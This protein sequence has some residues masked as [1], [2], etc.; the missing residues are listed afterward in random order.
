MVNARILRTLDVSAPPGEDAIEYLSAASGLALIGR[1]LYVIADDEHSLGVFDLGDSGPGRLFR[2]FAGQLP[3][4]HKDRKAGKP[5]LEAMAV[6]P[7]FESHPFG[8]LLAVGSGSKP[9]RQRA[10]LLR[11]DGN[12]AIDGS[13]R[14]VDLGPLYDPLRNRFP[15]LNIEGLFVA[16]GE[17]C[18]LQRG[19]RASRVNACV[20]FAWPDIEQWIRGIG[21]TPSCRSV[22]VFELGE[23][24]GVPLSFT[25]AAGLTTGGWVFCAAAED[26]SD[27]YADGHCAGSAVGIVSAE[28][29]LVLL[30]PIDLA[31][32]AEGIAV[33]DDGKGFE[34]LLVTDGDDR[35]VPA[36]LL[37][38]TLPR[39]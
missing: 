14:H 22:S 3:Q 13:A 18:L 11:L 31:C 33:A 35:G 19:N 1:R 37:S 25:D 17:L 9:N 36:Q 4:R 21:P 7:A 29:R 38:V 26:T 10:A 2:L 5:D 12:G 27:S 30:E 23:V 20:R 34:L 16:G 32:K 6:L 8:A 24:E 15:D 28:G 39:A